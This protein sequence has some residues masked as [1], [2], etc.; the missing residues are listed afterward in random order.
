MKK[1]SYLSTA[2]ALVIST[3]VLAAQ[4]PP[5]AGPTALSIVLDSAW[6][7]DYEMSDYKSL[8]R[9]VIA[10]RRPGDYLEIITGHPGKA[11]LR[12]AQ[13]I[14][15][16]DA[17]ELKNITALLNGVNCP[18][19][20]DVNI[21]KAV[22]MALR[23]LVKSSEENT[24]AHTAVI[25]FTDGKLND[26]DVN[27]LLQLVGEFDK[28][29][30]SLLVTGTY[31]TNK[32]L[33]VAANQGKFVFSLISEAN[34]VVWLKQAVQKNSSNQPAIQ[35]TDQEQLLISKPAGPGG[36]AVVTERKPTTRRANDKDS[37]PFVRSRYEVGEV[38]TKQSVKEQVPQSGISLTEPAQK[39]QPPVAGEPKSNVRMAEEKTLSIKTRIDSE[40]SIA[41]DGEPGRIKTTE[42]ENV[43]EPVVA[44][45][46]DKTPVSVGEA[47][48]I[49]TPSLAE[50]KRTPASPN[51]K[52]GL[53]MALRKAWPWLIGLG[54]A[55]LAVVGVVVTVALRNARK[56]Q[57]GSNSLLSTNRAKTKG[58]LVVE[59]NSQKYGLGKFDCF[60]SADVGS[61]PNNAVKIPHKSVKDKHVRLFRKSE[62]LMIK[63]LAR[64]AIIVSGSKIKP[65]QKHNLSLPA[66]IRLSEDVQFTVRLVPNNVQSDSNGS[67]DNEAK[68]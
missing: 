29:N 50:E 37:N 65:G 54:S 21:S 49:E 62:D 31:A 12:V 32:K 4:S 57:T 42:S 53:V 5:K 8:S 17:Q 7:N 18:I 64:S 2:V 14:K 26:S 60:T 19:F 3:N 27:H 22:D 39:S 46:G 43:A 55:L 13:F 41:P 66:R 38:P 23:R 67:V 20:S 33:L 25:V 48:P 24:F 44:E 68:K 9:Q 15:T 30:W 47:T 1:K 28:R 16:G 35:R 11:R 61:G 6:T 40:V 59:V 51:E 10:S 45:T 56:W 34:P 52:S 63:N 58:G 36:L